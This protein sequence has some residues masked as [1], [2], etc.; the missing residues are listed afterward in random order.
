MKY[1][2]YLDFR[3]LIDIQTFL[4]GFSHYIFPVFLSQDPKLIILSTSKDYFCFLYTILHG[5]T[6]KLS[7]LIPVDQVWCSPMYLLKTKKLCSNSTISKQCHGCPLS[8]FYLL[9]SSVPGVTGIVLVLILFLMLM[10][11]SYCVR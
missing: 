2:F 10:S 8:F 3:K 4:L 5:R 9:F 11:S 6:K 1:V 7:S